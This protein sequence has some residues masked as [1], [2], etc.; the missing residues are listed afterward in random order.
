VRQP[1][2]IPSSRQAADIGHDLYSVRVFGERSQYIQPL[3]PSCS[4]VRPSKSSRTQSITI[5]QSLGH[6][7]GFVHR[8]TI[9]DGFVG[10][11]FTRRDIGDF[12]YRSQVFHS[13][14]QLALVEV[15][16]VTVCLI[17]TPDNRAFGAARK[18]P[19]AGR[20]SPGA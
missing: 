20:A 9:N 6:E 14:V 7:L 17:S 19:S 18:T 15:L 10:P 2:K 4:D 5:V 16:T 11:A 1:R 3:V 12:K 8:R 13:F